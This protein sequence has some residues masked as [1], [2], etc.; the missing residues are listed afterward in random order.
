MKWH[1]RHHAMLTAIFCQKYVS[2]IWTAF[3]TIHIIYNLYAY[4]HPFHTPNYV[5]IY[6][7]VCDFLL[8][9]ILTYFY[10]LFKNFPSTYIY[11]FTSVFDFMQL[12]PHSVLLPC[13]CA[14]VLSIAFTQV[15]SHLLPTTI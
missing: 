7:C 2:I 9:T 1:Q 12:I 10:V 15:Y 11:I 8:L 3:H 4:R 5:F 6:E 14:F 13:V